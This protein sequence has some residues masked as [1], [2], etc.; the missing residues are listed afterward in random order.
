MNTI[1]K[2]KRT[3]SSSDKF[4]IEV[5]YEPLVKLLE[6]NK[7]PVQLSFIISNVEKLIE[8]EQYSIQVK[9]YRCRMVL[10]LNKRE[11]I[12]I[13]EGCSK[14]DAV[15]YALSYIRKRLQEY[16]ATEKEIVKIEEKKEEEVEEK[17][18]ESVSTKLP[19]TE[20]EELEE[21]LN[22][23]SSSFK[24]LSKKAAKEEKEKLKQEQREAE[25]ERLRKI[26]EQEEL[27]K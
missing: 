21:L 26:K 14:V 10:K 2:F 15:W 16:L 7:I 19:L 8:E 12:E 20:E 27:L 13:E 6:E 22:S 9:S 3:L 23:Q 25:K 1:A 5:A 17:K 18:D 11:I 4:R 24:K